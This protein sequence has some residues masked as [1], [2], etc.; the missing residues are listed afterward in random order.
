[1]LNMQENGNMQQSRNTQGYASESLLESEEFVSEVATPQETVYNHA[2][3]D[4]LY[5]EVVQ[6]IEQEAK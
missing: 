4:A 1:M 3:L 6:A 5:L 2:E